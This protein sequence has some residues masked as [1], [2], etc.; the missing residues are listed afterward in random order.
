[1]NLILV[2]GFWLGAWSWDRVTP[3][4]KAAGHS[5]T[6]ITLPGLDSVHTDRRGISMAGTVSALVEVIDQTPGKVVL[7]GH[8]GG[9]S[10]AYGAVDQRPGKVERVIYVDSRPKPSG[11]T[12]NTELP[13]NSVEIPLPSWDEFRA[14]D[15]V[16]LRDLSDDML[17]EFRARAVPEPWGV[18][19]DPL[20]LS[21]PARLEVPATIISTTYSREQIEEGIRSG[22][23]RFAELRRIREVEI[24]ELP[25]GH[26]PQFSK[27]DE[28][29]QHI[30]AVLSG[31]SRPRETAR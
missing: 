30:L 22:E 19:N 21:N 7:V 25:T 18:A 1:M 9:G 24:I 10:V 13:G 16:D 3:A 11:S 17:A 29:A 31:R 5:V 23:P 8:S 15:D 4:L 12:V 20:M 14:D 27:P 26:W 28:L 6:A 2:P